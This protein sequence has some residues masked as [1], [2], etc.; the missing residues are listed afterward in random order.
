MTLI[1]LNEN[2]SSCPTGLI[3]SG[4]LSASCEQ[5]AGTLRPLDPGSRDN[6]AP[7]EQQQA[8]SQIYSNL[9]RRI[10]AELCSAGNMTFSQWQLNLTDD[11]VLRVQ[12]CLCEKPHTRT[13][14]KKTLTLKH[15]YVSI[16][17][18]FYLV[19]QIFW[20]HFSC[21]RSLHSCL[22]TQLLINTTAHSSLVTLL[23]RAE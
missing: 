6:V 14:C 10:P 23:E 16:S 21:E 3:T 8:I 11:C 18:L 13:S 20:S 4:L 9:R 2:L 22:Y 15:G 19:S 12:V 1:K 7:V 17:P 5:T